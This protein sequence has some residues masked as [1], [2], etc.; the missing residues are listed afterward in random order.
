MGLTLFRLNPDLGV[1]DQATV[2]RDVRSA[3]ERNQ[4]TLAKLHGDGTQFP[5]RVLALIDQYI[6]AA[7]QADDESNEADQ[8]LAARTAVYQE[9]R[10][11]AVD[12]RAKVSLYRRCAAGVAVAFGLL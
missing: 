3:A 8:A 10:A 1:A 12:A 7:D 6:Q 9:A 2:L 4:E 11:Y 5:K